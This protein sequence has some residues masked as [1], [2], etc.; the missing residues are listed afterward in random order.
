M[1]LNLAGIFLS[2]NCDDYGGA[3]GVGCSY[4]DGDNGK[5]TVMIMIMITIMIMMLPLFFEVTSLS[6]MPR[7]ENEIIFSDSWYSMKYI[8]RKF[9]LNIRFE[10]MHTKKRQMPS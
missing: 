4:D 5:M 3:W 9:I 7:F 6:G 10:F 1:P 8:E 2:L